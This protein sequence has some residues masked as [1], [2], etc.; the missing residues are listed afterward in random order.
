MDELN[1]LTQEEA[2]RNGVFWALYSDS[3]LDT[4][5][6]S[7]GA[8]G[9]LIIEQASLHENSL[10]PFTGRAS[11]PGQDGVHSNLRLVSVACASTSNGTGLKISQP[12]FFGLLDA[13]SV[14]RHALYLIQ[15]EYDGFHIIPNGPTM[16]FFIGTW[17]Y[18]LAWSFDPSDLSTRAIFID[19]SR[20][21][22]A[23]FVELLKRF[24]QYTSSPA[25]LAFVTAV[26]VTRFD[27]TTTSHELAHI[28]FVAR[29]IGYDSRR[30]VKSGMKHDINKLTNYHQLIGGTL[31]NIANKL[32]HLGL[33][34]SLFTFV[35]EDPTFSTPISGTMMEGMLVNTEYLRRAVPVL[36]SQRDAYGEYV[37]YQKEQAERLSEVL[38]GLLTHEDSL[39]NIN[40]ANL[41]TELARAS[42]EDS[43][44]MKAIAILTMAFL[45]AT[46]F[47]TLFAL[48]TLESETVVLDI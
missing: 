12:N 25:L 1:A 18:A 47:A 34:D 48:P 42:K 38:F 37:R 6:A 43:S 21:C 23:P 5:S 13:M 40:I 3:T 36:R 32:R 35:M 10:L 9:L 27:D 4:L 15:N 28:H 44:T 31:E 30:H 14:N 41:S 26:H 8:N 39:I 17:L 20:D 29:E 24:L 2:S 45:P 16:T 33:V 11:I 19:R 46:F 7:R 22:Y